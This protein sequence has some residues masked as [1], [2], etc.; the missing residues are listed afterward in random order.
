MNELKDFLNSLK[1]GLLNRNQISKLQTLLQRYWHQFKGSDE[2]K[3]VGYKLLRGIEDV[4]WDPP[5]L[6]FTIERHGI[7]MLGSSRAD[8]Q[9]WTLNIEDETVTA[10]TLDTYR[11]IYSRQSPLKVG[12]IAEDLY[13][14]ITN[15]IV[16]DRIKRYSDGRIEIRIGNI[17]ELKEGSAVK[18]TLMQRRKRFRLKMDE[19]LLNS[20]W[21]KIRENLYR[22]GNTKS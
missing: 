4:E 18:Q 17:N 7:T 15:N 12:L 5:K 10:N 9:M 16:D 21:E 11:Q 19:L 6:F 2:T 14:K 13:Q 20:G 3:M 22:P 8:L 1:P